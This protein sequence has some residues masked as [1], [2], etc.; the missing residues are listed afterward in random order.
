MRTIHEALRYA[1]SRLAGS[2]IEDP[3]RDAELLLEH[4]L[5]ME[6]AELYL[7]RE[8]LLVDEPLFWPMIERRGRREPLAYITN[9]QG[10]WTMDLRVEPGVF[11]PRRET[12]HV[13]EHALG[14]LRGFREP[15]LLD[16][17]TGSG[18]IALSLTAERADAVVFASDSAE[19]ACRL[20]R[21]NRQILGLED[22]LVLLHGDLY[23]PL[24]DLCETFDMITCNPP[25]IGIQERDDL[26]EEVRFWEPAQ[27]L[28]GGQDGTEYYPRILR[29]GR[30]FLKA[31]G[32]MV[33]E[34]G[35]SQGKTVARMASE[36]GYVRI[37]I[38]KDYSGNDRVLCGQK[39]ARCLSGPLE[40]SGSW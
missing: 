29:G 31:G 4:L 2:G 13:V 8:R 9:L 33:L 36:L 19:R 20:A 21:L 1:E 15:R 37:R 32:W 25:Y 40:R 38:G 17:A 28:F 23:H 12:E 30:R 18:A 22:R 24:H 11:I 26:Q 16:L 39:D 3:R 7:N 34:I 10:F 35:A 5:G 27:A 6:R 14:L